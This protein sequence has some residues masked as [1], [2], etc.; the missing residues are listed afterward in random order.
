[1]R[2]SWDCGIYVSV[3]LCF[4]GFLL[5]PISRLSPDPEIDLDADFVYGK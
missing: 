4:Y 2:P 5:M 1:M 3:E